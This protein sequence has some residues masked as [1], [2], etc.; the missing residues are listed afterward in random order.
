MDYPVEFC[1]SLVPA[2][3]NS[4]GTDSLHWYCYNVW[5]SGT[6]LC[7]AYGLVFCVGLLGDD[8]KISTT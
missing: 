2:N 3:V 6:G 4:N 8:N 5:V 1:L 7:T